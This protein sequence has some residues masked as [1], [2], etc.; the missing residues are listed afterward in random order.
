MIQFYIVTVSTPRQTCRRELISHAKT[1][2]KT[3][4]QWPQIISDAAVGCGC[5]QG[6][7]GSTLTFPPPKETLCLLN[8]S[9]CAQWQLYLQYRVA[10]AT[11]TA[12]TECALWRA[13]LSPAQTDNHLTDIGGDSSTVAYGNRLLT[14]KT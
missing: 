6:R 11:V 8:S 14:A 5:G 12:L 4:L 7:M 10:C 13:L 2:K 1:T 3:L 9:T